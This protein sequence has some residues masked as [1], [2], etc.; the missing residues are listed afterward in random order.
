MLGG[1]W[2]HDLCGKVLGA[3]GRRQ[4]Y[5]SSY[6]VSIGL[7]KDVRIDV[8]LEAINSP[9]LYCQCCF[10]EANREA[11]AAI[12]ALSIIPAEAGRLV[13]VCKDKALANSLLGHL[14][15]ADGYKRFHDRISI[16]LFGDA[17]EHYHKRSD[18]DWL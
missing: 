10:S 17:L 7:L 1:S 3:I 14:K 15:K 13:L 16:K 12:R 6:E 11:E 8:V 5:R 9:R 2:E 4:N 18:R